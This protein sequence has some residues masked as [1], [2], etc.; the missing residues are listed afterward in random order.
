MAKCPRR[1]V[2]RPGVGASANKPVLTIEELRSFAT[3][4]AVL[5]GITTFT[6]DLISLDSEQ[7]NSSSADSHLRDQPFET[8]NADDY[9]APSAPDLLASQF[10]SVFRRSG[11]RQ[12]YLALFNNDAFPHSIAVDLEQLFSAQV[13]PKQCT[14]FWTGEKVDLRGSILEM[15]VPPHGCRF[16][17]LPK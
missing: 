16:F 1:I 17:I 8:G 11:L 13:F 3:A 7:P 2:L 9:S 15:T 5:G 6:D 14:D 10:P 12:D 4:A